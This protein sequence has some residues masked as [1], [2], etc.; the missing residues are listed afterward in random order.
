MSSEYN[1]KSIE[2]QK[3]IVKILSDYLPA[4]PEC[5]LDEKGLL[6]YAG[7][8]EIYDF[9]KFKEAVF[10]AVV[11]C[12]TYPTIADIVSEIHQLPK[13]RKYIDVN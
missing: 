2:R 9:D 12:R 4:F 10:N 5:K 7:A 3:E 6:V 8:L 1:N 11:H 13:S